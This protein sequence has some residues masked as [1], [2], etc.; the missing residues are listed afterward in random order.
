MIDVKHKW[1]KIYGCYAYPNKK[2][3]Y[4]LTCSINLNISV[5]CV[6]NYKTKEKYIV[7]KVKQQFDNLTIIHDKP[8]DGGC[9]KKR[10]DIYIDLG[11]RVIII[12]IDED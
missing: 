12:E 7:E 3:D 11:H 6:R 2:S 10:P 5:G 8:I 1:C 9:S 4:C